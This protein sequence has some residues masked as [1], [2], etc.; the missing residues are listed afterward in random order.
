[1]AWKAN[2]DVFSFPIAPQGSLINC[3]ADNH[4]MSNKETLY[5]GE[6]NQSMVVLCYSSMRPELEH[7][8]SKGNYLYQG[9]YNRTL[10]G[11]RIDQMPNNGVIR[12]NSI[13]DGYSGEPFIFHVR[14]AGKYLYI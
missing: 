5:V 8:S 12:L 1:M 13:I 7:G 9:V 14:F 2:N 3:E 10:V 11:V 6:N 4:V